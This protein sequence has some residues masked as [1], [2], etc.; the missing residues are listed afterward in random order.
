MI[1]I[2]DDIPSIEQ[3]TEVEN[4]SEEDLQEQNSKMITGLTSNV[5]GNLELG[6][7]CFATTAIGKVRENQE[8]AVAL[9]K[10]RDISEFKMMVVA[11]G[12]GGEK[13]GE[14]A[15]H[16]IVT[17]LKEWFES[18]SSEEKESYYNEVSNIEEA[19]KNKIQEISFQIEWDLYGLGG[20]TLVCALI[21]KSDT[22]IA[23]VGDSRG[24]IIKNG[25]LQ[26][27]TTDDSAVQ[28]E[29]EKGNI[30]F[31]DAMRFHKN[32]AEL[33]QAVGMGRIEYVHTKILSNNDYDMLLLFSD[34]VTDCLSEDDIAVICSTTNRKEVAKMIVKKANEHDSI[35]PEELY[36]DYVNFNRYIPGGKDN[37]TVA[38]FEQKKDDE[39]ER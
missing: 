33:T 38:I 29:L 11:D 25:K 23:N 17:K 36:G 1:N 9:I 4:I 32:S 8:D 15:S 39:E 26:Q 27:I 19:L 6:E 14:V 2:Y 21:G 28:K 13:R 35:G 37:T 5:E 20:A 24:Y 22:I 3:Q 34:G 7:D 16:I 12:M 30:P 18:L 31:K 10:D